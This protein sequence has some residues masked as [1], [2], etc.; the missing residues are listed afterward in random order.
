MKHEIKLKSEYAIAQKLGVKPWELRK[1]DRDYKLD[2][3]L[4]YTV[5]D[6][7]G[8]IVDQYKVQIV[9]MFEGGKYEI[10]RASCRER[11]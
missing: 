2:D 8:H 3:I 11:V 1:N 9:Y 10:G 7:N 6:P 5:I 4:S